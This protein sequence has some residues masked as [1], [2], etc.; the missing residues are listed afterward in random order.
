MVRGIY[1]S[2]S[3]MQY[4]LLKQEVTANNLANV[5]TTGFKRQGVFR[6]TLTDV[7]RL[8]QQ[9]TTDFVNLEEVDDTRTVHTAGAFATTNN[10]LD[11]A[12][13]GPAFLTVDSPNGP[14]YTRNGSLTVGNDG[15]LQ[16][17][18]G[19]PVSGLAG[20]VQ[21]IG[22]EVFIA[23]DGQVFVDGVLQDQLQL[24]TFAEP[25]QLTREGDGLYN[26][27]DAIPT[28]SLFP[29]SRIR[30]G[31]LEDSNVEALDEMVAMIAT[32]RGF[33]AGQRALTMQDETLR[34]TVND[35]GRVRAQ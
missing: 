25:W 20:P 32:N 11:I 3:G 29:E 35:V 18:H 28:T 33:E 21:I 34:R 8:A 12:I 19:Y 26:A 23:D 6:R 24:A 31:V 10:P 1:S 15:V 30:Q 9:H 16:T 17:S 13:D 7:E 2:A 22:D 14:R 5:N 4:L 27:G